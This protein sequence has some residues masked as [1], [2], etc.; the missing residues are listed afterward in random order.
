[1]FIFDVWICVRRKDA[2]KQ[3]APTSL[4]ICMQIW[5]EKSCRDFLYTE[6]P[7]AVEWKIENTKPE[8]KEGIY[9]YDVLESVWNLRPGAL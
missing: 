5:Y 4:R 8:Q 2:Q 9:I 6:S 7:L 1:M 3:L